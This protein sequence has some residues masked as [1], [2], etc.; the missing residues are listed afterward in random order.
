MT[1]IFLESLDFR[2]LCE[3]QPSC[4]SSIWPGSQ[5]TNHAHHWTLA[6]SPNRTSG[7]VADWVQQTHFLP[8]THPALLDSWYFMTWHW[9]GRGEK[10]EATSIQGRKKMSG[11]RMEPHCALPTLPPPFGNGLNHVTCQVAEMS[12]CLERQSCWKETRPKDP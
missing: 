10:G 9:R 7:P 3:I 1:A 12:E 8:S 5:P 4:I 2:W 6:S 11:H